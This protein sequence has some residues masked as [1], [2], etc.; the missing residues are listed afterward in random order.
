MYGQRPRQ[1]FLQQP[2]QQQQHHQQHAAHFGLLTTVNRMAEAASHAANAANSDAAGAAAD[3][4]VG[5]ASIISDIMRGF[6]D[7]VRPLDDTVALVERILL[8]QLRAILNALLEAAD[9]RCG[10][11]KPTRT[12]F[13]FLMRK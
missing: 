1:P 13:E 3:D 9:R 2:H 4:E 6:G 12:D 7:C 5:F 11:P 8:Q 10:Q